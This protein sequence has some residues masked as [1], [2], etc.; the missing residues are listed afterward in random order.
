MGIYT[1]QLQAH[2]DRFEAVLPGQA[3]QPADSSEE[4]LLKS[5]GETF[6]KENFMIQEDI[7]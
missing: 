3:A 6:G 2:C 4:S 1:N 7:K 5:L